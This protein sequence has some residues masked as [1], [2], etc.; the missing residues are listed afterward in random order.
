[1]ILI[2]EEKS[3][4]R[5]RNLGPLFRRLLAR[6]IPFSPYWVSIWILLLSACGAKQ[7]YFVLLSDPDGKIGKIEVAN[8]GGA[9]VLSQA[10]QAI[11]V[12]SINKAPGTPF[13]MDQKQLTELFGEALS[14]QPEPP[15]VFILYFKFGSTDL[16]E[17]SQKVLPEILEKIKKRK[18]P[19]ISIIGHTDRVGPRDFNYTIGLNRAKAFLNQLVL[20][21]L[22]PKKIELI[23]H[24]EDNPLIK[25]KDEVPEPR[26]RRIEVVIR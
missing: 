10:R 24:G 6:I 20:L 14:A 26:N 13:I 17:E 22:D 2:P 3:S 25:T 5:A 1:M 21:G 19:E 9:Q 8:K 7:N 18:L 23:S 15:L 12:D 11:R 4:W 16:N